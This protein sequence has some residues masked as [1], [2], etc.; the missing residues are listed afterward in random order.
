M[1]I[2]GSPALRPRRT[3]GSRAELHGEL[4]QRVDVGL[5]RGHDDV[6]VGAH[7]VDDA[8]ALGQPH[9]H[10]A[11]RVGA[12]GDVVHRVEQQ[13]GAALPRCSRSP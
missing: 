1:R 3:A 8:P 7:A 12:A 6:G 10:L 4:V 5:G 2:R 13:L 9:R 11:L